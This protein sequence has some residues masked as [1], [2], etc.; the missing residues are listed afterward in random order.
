MGATNREQLELLVHDMEDMANAIEARGGRCNAEENQK[1]KQMAAESK[2]L[3]A[4]IRA[5]AGADFAG[6]TGKQLLAAMSA[7][8]RANDSKSYL[9]DLASPGGSYDGSAPASYSSKGQSWGD[10]VVKANSNEYG[11]KALLASGSTA[12]SVP[13]AVDP[14]R[15]GERL[16]FL[17]QLI[18][19]E[20][21]DVGRFSYLRQTTRTNLAAVVAEGA[22]KPTSIYTLT[23]VDDRARVIAHLSEQ[24]ARQSIDDAAL[25]KQFIEQ[26]MRLGLAL[27]LDDEILN[28]DGTGEHF[29][30]ILSAAATTAGVQPQA[31]S[32]NMLVTIRKAITKLEVIDL[33]ADGIV[34]NPA[35]WE[36]MEL[37]LDGANGDFILEESLPIDRA[38]RRLWGVPVLVTNAIPAGVGLVGDFRGSSRLWIREEAKLDWSENI[39]SDF[40]LNYVRFRA[41]MRAGFGLLRPTGF[42]NTDLT[43]A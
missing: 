2:R 23:R 28:G 11:F 8:P 10:A 1:L 36:T 30:G 33:A 32:T 25:L 7:P 34:V 18:P 12:V 6:L 16:Q 35:D 43:A 4:I 22:T 17:R 26:E 14:V 40:T 3:S 29:V 37:M 20:R 39:A 42:V 41:E 31:W 13:L 5:E 9:A 24:I 19:T 38:T 15:P 27:E 21:D